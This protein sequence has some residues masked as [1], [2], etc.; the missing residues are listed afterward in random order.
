LLTGDAKAIST[1][2]GNQL[3][4]DEGLAKLWPDDKMAH[5]EP[6]IKGGKRD[7]R[8]KFAGLRPGPPVWK[9]TPVLGRVANR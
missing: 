6:L 9:S 5:I 3:G 1:D 7:G 2:M 4:V 8:L